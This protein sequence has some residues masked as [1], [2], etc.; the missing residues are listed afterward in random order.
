[1]LLSVS[2]KETA[3]VNHDAKKEQYEPDKWLKY[4]NFSP[5]YVKNKNF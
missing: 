3:K 4:N 5:L 1:M 2:Q